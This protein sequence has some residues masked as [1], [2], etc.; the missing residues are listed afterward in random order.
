MVTKPD[1]ASS[2]HLSRIRDARHLSLT[3]SHDNSLVLLFGSS[4][5]IR[6]VIYSDSLKIIAEIRK[7]KRFGWGYVFTVR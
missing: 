7:Q 4:W 1:R 6:N 3:P 5:T 2:C